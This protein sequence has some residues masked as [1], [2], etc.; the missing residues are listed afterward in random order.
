MNYSIY[1]L[2]NPDGKFYIGQTGDL[3]RRSQQHNDPGTRSQGR[4]LIRLR[5][6]IGLNPTRLRREG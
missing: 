2:R 4:E 1:V 3:E 6:I 5:R